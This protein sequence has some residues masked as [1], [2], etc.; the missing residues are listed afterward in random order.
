MKVVLVFDTAYGADPQA[1]LGE[2]FWLVESPSNR[3]LAL[4]AWQSGSTDLN[5]AVFDPPPGPPAWEDVVGRVED[6]ELHH[7]NWSVIEVV[8]VEPMPQF[9]AVMSEAGHKIISRTGCISIQR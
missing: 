3:A 2:A 1:D 9:C 8:G 6:I 4:T 7:P 5:S